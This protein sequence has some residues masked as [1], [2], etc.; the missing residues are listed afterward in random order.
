MTSKPEADNNRLVVLTPQIQFDKG[1]NSALCRLSVSDNSLYEGRNQFT[2]S[3][4]SPDKV[5]VG[6]REL[7]MISLDDPEDGEIVTV[8]L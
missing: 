7:A 5:L 1:D 6:Q 2:L 8:F 4:T 3:L